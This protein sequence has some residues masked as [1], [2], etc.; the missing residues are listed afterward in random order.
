MGDPAY[1]GGTLIKSR[2]LTLIGADDPRKALHRTLDVFAEAAELDREHARCWAQLHA[3]QAA[4]W[5]RRHDF[6]ISLGGSQPTAL[7]AFMEHLAELL[8]DPV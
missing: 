5:G 2:A 6:R 8:T 4:F 7:T 1:D 3:V